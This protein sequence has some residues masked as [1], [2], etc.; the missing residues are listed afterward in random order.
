MLRHLYRVRSWTASYVKQK[1]SRN[2]L[3]LTAGKPCEGMQRKRVCYVSSGSKP[4]LW[5]RSDSGLPS[6]QMQFHI[7]IP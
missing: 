1:L 3:P 2:K 6:D 4:G 5:I 7:T